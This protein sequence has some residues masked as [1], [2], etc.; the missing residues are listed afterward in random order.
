MTIMIVAFMGTCSF[1]FIEVIKTQKSINFKP[2]QT[3][4]TQL[5]TESMPLNQTTLTESKHDVRLQDENE[6]LNDEI[7]NES[8]DSK[9]L[10]SSNVQSSDVNEDDQIYKDYSD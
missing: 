3:Q 1:C 5:T 4:S 7:R 2:K 6:I 10:K 9:E 8:F